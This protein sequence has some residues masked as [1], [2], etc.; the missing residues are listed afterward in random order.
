MVLLFSFF[1][2]LDTITNVDCL[3]WEFLFQWLFLLYFWKLGWLFENQLG[4]E[5]PNPSKDNDC[6]FPPSPHFEFWINLRIF[7]WFSAVPVYS[8][9][10]FIVVGVWWFLVILGCFVV[11][12]PWRQHGLLNCVLL[13]IITMRHSSSYIYILCKVILRMHQNIWLSNLLS[14]DSFWCSVWLMAWLLVAAYLRCIW[15]VFSVWF[16]VAFVL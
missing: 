6:L 10:S 12:L 2:I 13:Y 7:S 11:V 1:C 3:L 5:M 14:L 8:S 4:T 15:L 16:W 9:S